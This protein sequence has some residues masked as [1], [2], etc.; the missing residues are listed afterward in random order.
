[1]SKKNARSRKWA[2]DR[3]PDSGSK[4]LSESPD[5]AISGENHFATRR[6][7]NAFVSLMR[8]LPD[9]DPLLSRMGKGIPALRELLADSHLEAVWSVRCSTAAGAEWFVEAG[10]E[11]AQEKEA[12]G[13]FES[14][15]KNLDV[16]RIIEEMMDAVAYGY[17]PL[18]IIWEAHE[19]KWGIGNIVGKPAEWFEFTPENRLVLRTGS[20]GQ[21]EPP[22]NRFLLVQ[23]WASYVNPYGSKVFSKCY[24]PLTFKK[25]GWQWWAVFV[26]K[27]GGA[28]LFGKYPNNVDDKYK[29]DLLDALEALVA[30]SVAILPEGSEVTIE[31]LANKGAASSIHK[32]FIDTANAEVSK[33]VLGQTLTTEIGNKGSYA[34]AQAHNLVRKDLAESDRRRISAAFNRLAAVYTFYNFG[35][36]VTPPRFEFVQDEDLQIERAKRDVLIPQMGWRPT[37]SYVSREYGIP[38]EELEPAGETSGGG[39]F[40]NR[41]AAAPYTGQDSRRNRSPVGLFASKTDRAA[42]RDE[43][44]MGEFSGLMARAGQQ[45]LDEAVESYVDALGTVDNFEDA[46]AV[47]QKAYRRRDAGGFA[48]LI[49][50][51]RY[52]AAGIGGAR[53]RRG[54]HGN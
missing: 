23:H 3:R 19:G 51:V 43:R 21:E 5:A 37:K 26:E 24:W 54:K 38:E 18:E 50:E 46:A 13:S 32:E 39:L 17:S 22:E 16:P 9:T 25:K 34:A 52:A 27:Y 28:F 41:P 29:A 2:P 33:A 31:S 7:L 36:G 14:E 4:S 10:A 11:G 44:L 42:A 53:R 30:D 40:S 1:M 45:E 12:A 20:G 8:T 35:G 47:L 49:D 48:G 6:R 15:L